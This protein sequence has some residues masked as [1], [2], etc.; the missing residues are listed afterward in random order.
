[1]KRRDI[2]EHITEAATSHHRLQAGE[3]QR[4]RQLIHEKVRTNYYL[5]FI[6]Y[7]F[8]YIYDWIYENRVNAVEPNDPYTL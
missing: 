3:I 4:L 1:M 2:N 7:D 5:T 6:A 8:Q